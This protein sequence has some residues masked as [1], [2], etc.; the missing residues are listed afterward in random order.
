[1]RNVPLGVVSIVLRAY[2]PYSPHLFLS[3][4]AITYEE[5]RNPFNQK[6]LES[7]RARS[8][9]SLVWNEKGLQSSC[10]SSLRQ[11]APE[12]WLGCHLPLFTVI[13]HHGLRYIFVH[14]KDSWFAPGS[15]LLDD[16]SRKILE[17]SASLMEGILR[18]RRSF[19]FSYSQPAWELLPGN[20]LLP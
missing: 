12:S 19:G 10:L 7:F 11:G 17:R 3:Q 4:T 14:W 20:S 9:D 5:V 15:K 8:L 18:L 13:K 1:M 6:L 16:L 2:L